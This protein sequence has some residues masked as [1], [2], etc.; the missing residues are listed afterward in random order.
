MGHSCR[1]EGVTSVDPART[2]K[3]SLCDRLASSEV[4]PSA[5]NISTTNADLR[6]VGDDHLLRG[7]GGGDGI[8]GKIQSS[9]ITES[10][11]I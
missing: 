8:C 3:D 6:A 1:A 7:A 10:D 2:A 4:R 5:H 11:K 9:A